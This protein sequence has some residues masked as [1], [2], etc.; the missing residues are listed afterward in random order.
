MTALPVPRGTRPHGPSPVARTPRRLLAAAVTV[1]LLAP[2]AAFAQTAKERE[3]E[4][5]VAQLERMV[6]Q[7]L[8]Q[9][10]QTSATVAET[11]AQVSEVRTA[12]AATP[13]AAAT[14]A[15]AWQVL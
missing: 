1:A 7:L 3:L 13:A 8:S 15:P 4:A 6:E 2:G 11:R 9:Q 5:R 14:P 10:Q 12:Q